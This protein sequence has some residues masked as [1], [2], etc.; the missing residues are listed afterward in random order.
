MSTSSP[1]AAASTS[2][3]TMRA[4]PILL[5]LVA[6]LLAAPASGAAATHNDMDT[7]NRDQKGGSECSN[8]YSYIVTGIRRKTAAA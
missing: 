1:R 6:A 8:D 3:L 7:C 5:A 4:T 2:S